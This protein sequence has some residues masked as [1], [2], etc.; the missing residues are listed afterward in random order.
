MAATVV[1]RSTYSDSCMNV[2]PLTEPVQSTRLVATTTELSAHLWSSVETAAQ[3]MLVLCH[4]STEFI[5]FR[6]MDA[7]Q[8]RQ[9]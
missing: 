6:S 1:G 2:T 9:T 4:L 5:K 8:L 3:V 7:Y